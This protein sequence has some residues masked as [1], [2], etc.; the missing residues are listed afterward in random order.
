M[1]FPRIR[2]QGTFE[3]NPAP[4]VPRRPLPCPPSSC[5][6]SVGA[7]V[8]RRVF[9]D[10]TAAVGVAPSDHCPKP[11]L[12]RQDKRNRVFQEDVTNGDKGKLLT[13][14][15]LQNPSEDCLKEYS[16]DTLCCV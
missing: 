7:Y 3:A 2:L 4:A 12:R 5:M 1:L 6:Y 15:R 13:V 16:T 11:T 10:T 9:C 8:Y 14:V